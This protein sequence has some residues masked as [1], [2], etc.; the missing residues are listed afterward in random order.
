MEMSTL[1]GGFADTPREA[2]VAFRTAMAAMARPG[3]IHDIAG[4]TPP[5]PLSPAAGTLL[6]ALA[7]PM[8]P[9]HLA[10]RTDTRAV[11]DWLTF[12]TGAPPAARAEAAFAVGSWAELLPLDAYRIGVPDY[13][14]RSATL[15]VEM[16]GLAS[17]GARLTGPGIETEHRLSLPDIEAFR[18][19]RARF[20]LGLDFFF[21]AGTRMAAL[22]RSTHVEAG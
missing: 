21:T 12:H 5:A 18:A 16:E 1:T 17:E 15:I 2:A 22:P 13:P 14:D 10:G 11:R 9:V 4:A 8:T 19:N 20:P 3:R 7:D 6:R